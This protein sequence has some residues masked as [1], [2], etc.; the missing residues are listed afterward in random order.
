MP[1]ARIMV[2]GGQA[3][4][5][6]DWNAFQRKLGGQ[7][8]PSDILYTHQYYIRWGRITLPKQY[9]Y[10]TSRPLANSSTGCQTASLLIPDPRRRAKGIF[11]GSPAW[12]ALDSKRLSTSVCRPVSCPWDT[13][14]SWSLAASSFF[15]SAATRHVLRLSRHPL[16][17]DAGAGNS[18]FP[19]KWEVQQ[20]R[21]G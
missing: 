13:T 1:R 18:S 7:L 10:R 2:S 12:R 17:P 15:P 11:P 9:F 20:W 16:K 8:R 19:S 3:I 5:H 14:L 4:F 21:V 6:P